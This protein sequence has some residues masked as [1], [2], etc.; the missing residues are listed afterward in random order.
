V[1][2]LFSLLISLFNVIALLHL[3]FFL[4]LAEKK[5]QKK[6]AVLQPA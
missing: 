5:E 4:L 1:K 6:N 2:K 3:P